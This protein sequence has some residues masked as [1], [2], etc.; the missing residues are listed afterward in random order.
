MVIPAQNIDFEDQS[1]TSMQNSPFLLDNEA[2]YQHWKKDK[3]ERYSRFSPDKIIKIEDH[4]CLSSKTL[5]EIASQ[6]E[7]FNFACF[8]LDAANRDFSTRDLLNFGQLLGL[9][10]VDTNLGAESDG[11][12]RLCVVESSDKRSRYI[13]YTNRALN[14]HT[15]G[16]YN[17]SS[18]RINAFSLYCVEPAEQGGE[19]FVL[20][21]EMLYMQIRDTDSELLVAL[22]D[23]NIMMVP[24]NISSNRV[25]RRAES[26]SVF[27]I[28]SETGRLNMRYSARPQNIR[29]KTDTLSMRAL[30]LVREI[31]IDSEYI[32]TQEP[33]SG[34]G[35]VC[36]NVLHG[37]KAFVDAQA[38]N[39]SRLYYRAR[40]YDAINLPG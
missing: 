16:Y 37:R 19:S 2:G 29:W 27:N 3:L 18:S 12:T 13:P 36:N 22:M 5:G 1:S 31:L 23:S 26:G 14:W 24:A 32:T 39:P 9:Y 15:D 4:S 21:H 35:M 6:I 38:G 11:V 10:R 34:Q 8:E 25:V 30:N 40:Y 33:E 7:S 28:D 20:D 17:P